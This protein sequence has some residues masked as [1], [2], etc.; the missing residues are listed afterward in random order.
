M[1]KSSGFY[2]LV[3]AFLFFIFPSIQTSA[4]EG[5]DVY[6]LPNGGNIYQED[7]QTIIEKSPAK[8]YVIILE[9]QEAWSKVRI[10]QLVGYVKNAAMSPATS[11][12]MKISSGSSP[13]LRETNTKAAKQLTSIPTGSYV[14]LFGQMDA[15]FSLIQTGAA[16]G[17]VYSSTLVKPIGT[18]MNV[19]YKNGA[20]IRFVPDMAQP[21]QAT[22]KTHTPVFAYPAI[23][24]WFY[25]DSSAG[26]GYALA[27]KLQK[28]MATTTP[29][30]QTSKKQIALTFDD[31]PHKTVTRQI[32]KTLAKYDAK[33][34]FFVTGRS[35][36]LHPIVLKE[37]FAAGHEI[38]NHTFDHVKLPTLAAKNAQLQITSTN[39]IIKNTI[40]QQPTLFRPPYG[41]YN[42]SIQALTDMPV[43]LWSVD[44]LDWQHRDAS[45]MLQI[46]KKQVKNGSI[47]L[48]HD[49][50][51]PT[52]NGL[53]AV[54]NYLSAEGYTFVTVS[55]LTTP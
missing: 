28:N 14:R 17:Y 52:A 20:A 25:V 22:L 51:Q 1:K 26:S 4:N 13:I 5:M 48:M 3:L 12:V 29:P 35:V 10:N 15:S 2:A 7:R 23:D 27:N 45:K 34:T 42:K 53:D 37:T 6:I 16:I 55:A 33:A 40:G 9:K 24:G 41:A 36:K 31:G 21:I 44:T 19:T 50:H 18:K 11:K 39:E 43:I 46:V 47:I 38:G 30:K 49:I 54:L 32:L 8:S